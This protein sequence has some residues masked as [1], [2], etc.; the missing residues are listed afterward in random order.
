MFR[1]PLQVEMLIARG[2]IVEQIEIDPQEGPGLLDEL[3]RPLIR[4]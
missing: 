1:L 2:R 3:L 4:P